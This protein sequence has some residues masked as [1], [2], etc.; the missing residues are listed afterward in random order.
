MHEHHFWKHFHHDNRDDRRDFGGRGGPFG[1][2]G[3]RRGGWFGF[4]PGGPGGFDVG[5]GRKLSSGELQLVLLALL[6]EKPRH[7]YDL[8]KAIDETSG[9]F[10]VP[11]PGVIYPALTYLEEAGEITAAAEGSRKLYS[12]TDAGREH[13]AKDRAVVDEILKR[14]EAIGERMGRV[15]EAFD[16]DDRDGDF[17]IPPSDFPPP[18]PGGRGPWGAHVELGQA[19]RDFHIAMR[20]A[21]RL[22]PEALVQIVGIIRRA[23]AAIRNVV[24]TEGR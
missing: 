3:G 1:G 18:F 14:L 24:E 12:L 6:H 4:G 5:R 10:Y 16:D 13:L 21:K 20:N 22:S 19:I 8:I 2:R 11:S 23:A 7:G 9:G 15:R 17:Q